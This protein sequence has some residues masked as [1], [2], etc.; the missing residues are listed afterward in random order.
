MMSF[1]TQREDLTERFIKVYLCPSLF[2][3]TNLLR[4]GSS[5]LQS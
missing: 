4:P 3:P 2:A 5:P 1:G